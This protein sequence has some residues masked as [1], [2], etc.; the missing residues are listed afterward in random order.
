[1]G[2]LIHSASRTQ[3]SIALSSAESELYV[4]CS[5]V[6]EALCLRNLMEESGISDDHVVINLQTDSSAAKPLASRSGPGREA[7]HSQ[8]K[9]L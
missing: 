9:C 8:A 5:A 2:N 6:S 1:M 4:M 3:S 7:R